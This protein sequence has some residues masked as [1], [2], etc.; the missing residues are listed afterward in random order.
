[1]LFAPASGPAPDC[2]SRAL[3]AWAR[4]LS[5]PGSRAA[6]SAVGLDI[7]G[8]VVSAGYAAPVSY[9]LKGIGADV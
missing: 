3:R 5:C 7:E 8:S 9:W 4:L 1:M 2:A 6:G